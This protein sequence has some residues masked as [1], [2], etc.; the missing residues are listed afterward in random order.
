[1]ASDTYEEERLRGLRETGWSEQEIHELNI[2]INE[3]NARL[4]WLYQLSKT[5]NN[6]GTAEIAAI[7][8]TT[9]ELTRKLR[10]KISEVEY[11][12]VLQVSLH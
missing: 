4:N 10:D 8:A 9:Q 12:L 2:E 6:A 1:M 11:S 7:T 5:P 3:H